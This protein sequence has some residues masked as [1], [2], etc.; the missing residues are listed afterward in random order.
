MKK[1]GWPPPPGR[2]ARLVWVSLVCAAG[3]VWVA[4]WQF[5]D[6]LLTFAAAEPAPVKVA[7]PVAAPTATCKKAEKLLAT[8]DTICFVTPHPDR[9]DCYSK[10]R[11]RFI[12]Y[13]PQ[14]RTPRA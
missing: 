1:D 14:Q 2:T 9:L 5:G 13:V 11:G 4:W 7:P 6:R 3:L 10:T 8:V 12:G